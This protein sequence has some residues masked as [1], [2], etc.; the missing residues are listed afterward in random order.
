VRDPIGGAV[1]IAAPVGQRWGA[2]QA[3]VAWGTPFLA[4]ALAGTEGKEGA[5]D[6]VQASVD[7]GREARTNPR[8]PSRGGGC[9]WDR[10]DSFAGGFTRAYPMGL[11]GDFGRVSRGVFRSGTFDPEA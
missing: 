8:D 7:Q 9:A 1:D 6:Q 5:K 4:R 3:L 2:P 11:L 10:P